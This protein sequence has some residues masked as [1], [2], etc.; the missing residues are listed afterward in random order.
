MNDAPRSLASVVLATRQPS[1]SGPMRFSTG[2]VDVVEEDLVELVLA[3]HLAQRTHVD[4]LGVHRDREHRDPL[5]RRRAAGRCAPARCPCRRRSRTTTT[6]SDRSRGT[7][8]RAS[9]ARVERLARSLPA[10]GSLNNWHQTSSAPRIR[11]IHRGALL[12]GAVRH[13]RRPDERD[14]GPAEERRRAARARAPRCRSRPAS[15]DAP[16]PPYSTGQWMP[17][18]R[19]ACSVRCQSRSVSASSGVAATSTAGGG[20]SASHDAQLVAELVVGR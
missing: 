8:R 16:R 11:G 5:V 20:C 17:T 18:Q 1:C 15:T 12:L 2:T 13:Q 3:G 14:A 4:A 10:P 19:P 6:P 9:R 7:R